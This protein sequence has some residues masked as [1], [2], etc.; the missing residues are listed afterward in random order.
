MGIYIK[1]Y[2]SICKDHLQKFIT[3]AE[4]TRGSWNNVECISATRVEYEIHCSL[5]C[6]WLQNEAE[7]SMN[8]Y[9][10]VPFW[11]NVHEIPVTMNFVVITRAITFKLDKT[12]S[13]EILRAIDELKNKESVGHDGKNNWLLKEWKEE[14]APSLVRL[15]NFSLT[16]C[17]FPAHLSMPSLEKVI[18]GS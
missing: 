5:I 15:L 7:L 12:N 2:I 6:P 3:L 4:L 1:I 18:V 9:S 17:D 13:Y 11:N 16:S 10:P 8:Y 14:L